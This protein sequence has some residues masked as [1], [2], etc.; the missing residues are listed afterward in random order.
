MYPKFAPWNFMGSP[1]EQFIDTMTTREDM[2]EID[3]FDTKAQLL[4]YQ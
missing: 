3:L 1:L 4:S 2:D